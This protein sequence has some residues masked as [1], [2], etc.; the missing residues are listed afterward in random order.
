MAERAALEFRTPDGIQ[1]AAVRTMSKQLRPGSVCR[2][3]TIAFN[4]CLVQRSEFHNFRPV[5]LLDA[6]VVPPVV[7]SPGQHVFI[8]FANFS[9]VRQ[10]KLQCFSPP[11]FL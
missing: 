5:C 10:I 2:F 6:F 11:P 8:I 1:L 4:R 7:T 3:R 9:T